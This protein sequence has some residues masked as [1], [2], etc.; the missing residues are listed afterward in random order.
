MNEAAFLQTLA[1]SRIGVSQQFPDKLAAE[2]FIDEV[3]H[4][5]FINNGED[6]DVTKAAVEYKR[7]QNN[8]SSLLAETISGEKTIRLQADTFFG[9]WP[10]IYKA[11][12]NDAQAI[13]EFDP[14]AQNI[15]EVIVAYPGFYA[16]V[17]YRLSHQLWKQGVRL[18]ARLFSE[19]AHGKTGIDIHPGAKIGNAFAI[20]HGTGIVIGETTVIGNRVKI[21]QGVTLGA[22]N[23]A[24][25]FR[26]TKRHPT[27]EN[28][29]VIYSGATILGGDT[30]VGEDSI[31]GGNVWITS[32][33]PPNSVVYHKSEIRIKDRNP[34]P[35]PINFI[36]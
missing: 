23:V 10:A 32:S 15:A 29:V 6:A 25:E 22:L 14:A 5:L 9:Q 31:I 1:E 28:N 11:L 19:Y 27:I 20:D 35:E 17:V 33:V 7:L 3:F 13:L 2:L 26:S 12:L 36:I 30:V 8:F 21:Y 18:L 34:F 24:K 16:T 4:F